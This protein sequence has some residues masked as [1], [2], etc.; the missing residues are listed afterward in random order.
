[1]ENISAYIFG[2]AIFAHEGSYLDIDSKIPTNWIELVKN[3]MRGLSPEIKIKWYQCTLCG[4][5]YEICEHEEGKEYDGVRCILAPRDIEF[6]SNS[7]VDNPKDPKA[8]I[9]DML[10][11][12]DNIKKKKYEWCGYKSDSSTFR[13]KHIQKAYEKKLIPEHAAIH[14][15]NYFQSHSEGNV[16]YPD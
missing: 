8:R 11:I 9:T 13:F 2:P 16:T 7:V 15:S 5:N 12:E 4:Q 6:L 10:I 14:F 3:G 1:M